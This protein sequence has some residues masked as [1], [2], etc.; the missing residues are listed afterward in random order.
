MW[1]SQKGGFGY[2]PTKIDYVFKGKNETKICVKVHKPLTPD[3]TKRSEAHFP[4]E[5][6]VSAKIDGMLKYQQ[7][8]DF[9][10]VSQ[11]FLRMILI[12]K[13]LIA[14]SHAGGVTLYS[15]QK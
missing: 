10:Q 9:I 4:I 1:I 12:V 13:K 2:K 7:N 15:R 8:R 3:D 5:F 14:S 6:D 11:E